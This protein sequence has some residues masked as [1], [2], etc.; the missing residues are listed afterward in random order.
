[1]AGDLARKPAPAAHNR[2]AE[3]VQDKEWGISCQSQAVACDSLLPWHWCVSALDSMSLVTGMLPGLHALQRRGNKPSH[4]MAHRSGRRVASGSPHWPLAA[5]AIAASRAQVRPTADRGPILL[6]VDTSGSMRGARE[7]VAKALAL[8]CMRAAREQER[9]CFVFAFA[10]PRDVRPALT[11]CMT[12]SSWPS[13]ARAA[14]AQPL[15]GVRRLAQRQGRL[16]VQ[17]SAQGVSSRW[18]LGLLA[19]ASP[20]HTGAVRAGADPGA[21]VQ[22]RELELNENLASVDNLLTFLESIFNGGSDFKC[23]PCQGRP[24]QPAAPAACPGICPGLH[25]PCRPA[26]ALLC[27]SLPPC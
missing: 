11:T 21:C 23:A 18:G 22:V 6:C 14:A 1:M 10:G 17:G 8:E 13:W 26:C 5:E 12:A 15:P 9:G 19:F 7:V 20:L 4:A 3:L 25:T 24:P 2:Y 16:P 27:S